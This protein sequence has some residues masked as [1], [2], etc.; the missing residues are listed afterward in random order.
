MRRNVAIVIMFLLA[1][2]I[3]SGCW[4][5][6]ELN[7]LGIVTGFGIDKVKGKYLLSTQVINPS[8]ITQKAPTGLPRA[9]VTTASVTSNTVFEGVRKMTMLSPRR[10]YFS[11][12]RVLILS[13]QV[14]REGVKDVLDLFFRDHEMRPDFYVLIS[15]NVK[16]IDILSS[17]VMLEKIPSN[18][19]YKSLEVTEKYFGASIAVHLDQFIADLTGPGKEP[20]LSGIE[21]TADSKKGQSEQTF[22]LIRPLTL[23]KL[24]SIGVFKDDKLIGWLDEKAS[25]GFNYVTNNV[26]GTISQVP[27]REGGKAIIEILRSK[28][29]MKGGATNGHPHVTV[30]IT[31]EGN[32]GEVEC[33]IDLTDTKNIY[34][35]ERQ[36]ERAIQQEIQQAVSQ[37]QKKYKSDIFGFGQAIHRGDPKLWKK[38]KPD[39]ER[40]FPALTVT[41]KVDVKIR[42]TGKVVNSVHQ[43]TEKSE[44][45]E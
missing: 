12:I 39:W 38:L 23:L 34:E 40:E 2:A 32:V 13:E 16:A 17:F 37:A 3:V 43:E 1:A 44:E 8:E 11:H 20:V 22:K 45:K 21:F 42:R 15:R 5:R 10:M 7:D 25:R 9:P 4:S 27:C 28:T 29:K 6:R 31:A 18:E 14:A 30:D 36:T 35:L 19:M 26:S 24:A 41:T 33:N